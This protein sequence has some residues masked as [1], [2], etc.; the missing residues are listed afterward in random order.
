MVKVANL[1]ADLTANT[2]RFE[3]GMKRAN[4]IMNQSRQQW[5]QALTQSSRGFDNLGRKTENVANQV[6]YLKA[7]FGGL[8]AA[9]ASAL[10]VQKVIQYSDTY[11]QLAGRISIITGDLESAGRMQEKLFELAQRT[12]TP[13]ASISDLY[14]KI[15]NGL[16]DSERKQYNVLGVTETF[17]KAL[18]NTGES[19]ASA[20]GAIL[21]FSQAIA[22]DFKSAGQELNSIIEQSPGVA[23]ALAEVFG[24]SIAGLKEMAK[25]GKITKEA[26]LKGL[27]PTLSAAAQRIATDFAKI[28]TT[29]GQALT[30]LDNAFLKFIGTNEDITRGTNSLALGIKQLADNFEILAQTIMYA[31]GAF[32]ALKIAKVIA[33]MVALKVAQA[34]VTIETNAQTAAILRNSAAMAV[35]SRMT[36]ALAKQQAAAIGS[37][38]QGVVV[39]NRL[40]VATVA[41]T[42]ALG[43]AGAAAALFGRGLLAAFGGPVGLAITALTAGIIYL[44]T[45]T[46]EAEE[47]AEKHAK[48]LDIVR[49]TTEQL[50]VVTGEA[51][52]E[53][54]RKR[55]AE[56]DAAEAAMLHAESLIEVA[57]AQAQATYEAALAARTLNPRAANL[58]DMGGLVNPDDAKK[59]AQENYELKAKRYNELLLQIRDTENANA[60]SSIKNSVDVGKAKKDVYKDI[61]EDLQNENQLAQ[62]RLR[63]YGQEEAAIKRAE[64][65]LQIKQRLESE[66]IRITEEQQ[67]QIDKYL[68]SIQ[69]QSQAYD[70]LEE[71]QK[72]LEEQ[73]KNRQRALDELGTT[74]ESAFED[75]I[76]SGEKLSDVLNALLQDILKLLVRM[77]ITAPIGNAITDMAGGGGFLSGLFG[78]GKEVYGPVQP[79]PSIFSGLFD[80]IGGFFNSFA[81]GTDYVSHDQLANIHKG[82]MIIPAREAAGI[83]AG[84]LG[85]NPKVNVT[86]VNNN[87]S[88][89]TQQSQESDNG[90]DL[91]VM[92]DEI[93]AGNI[94]KK[95]S[96]TNNA[97][98]QLNNQPLIRR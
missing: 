77:Q 74:F 30:Q 16:T 10:S 55:A 35:S 39:V 63:T 58:G 53:L 38:G 95:G 36:A 56:L 45:R 24:V 97:L 12:R 92:V 32:V 43:R 17:A 37:I 4:G 28:P 83:R 25:Q 34:A 84:K 49:E 40:G 46:T 65:A 91:I 19:A 42:T 75:A 88:K 59:A 78:G 94:S 79:T 67:K 9:A 20:Q 1:A 80:S 57:K 72:K 51:A 26:V 3:Q 71:Q 2:S 87:G 86:I 68:D 69:M 29:V 62:V 64:K 66:G 6:I 98:T 31:G 60:R 47:A 44:A 50:N 33:P 5:T 82:E 81:V 8:A 41:T 90:V 61:L 76:V 70:Q 93:V 27:D 7:Q 85:G 21:Q 73:E 11:K 15:N 18:T 54:E 14:I 13:L 48:S 23:K 96:R 22:G 52:E 89:V